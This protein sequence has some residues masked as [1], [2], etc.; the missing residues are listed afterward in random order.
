MS[1]TYMHIGIPVLNKKPGMVYKPRSAPTMPAKGARVS[2]LLFLTGMWF[3]CTYRQ[4][5]GIV[6]GSFGDVRDENRVLPTWFACI[7]KEY[8]AVLPK[9]SKRSASRRCPILILS[10]HRASY[11]GRIAGRVCAFRL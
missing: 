9:P 1:A 2:G 11:T 8:V 7:R 3:R 10:L 4:G 5:L 6:C